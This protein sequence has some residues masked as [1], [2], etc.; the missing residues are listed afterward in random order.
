[1]EANATNCPT[2]RLPSR[3]YRFGAAVE[4]ACHPLASSKHWPS[5]SFLGVGVGRRC[6]SPI[7]KLAARKL[8]SI[9]DATARRRAC[10]ATVRRLAEVVDANL[11]ML[12]SKAP[13]SLSLAFSSSALGMDELLLADLDRDRDGLA[14]DAYATSPTQIEQ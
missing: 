5:R 10:A 11:I 3:G 7:P 4:L 2:Q 6:W 8:G 1:M 14:D 13:H 9:L 12:R